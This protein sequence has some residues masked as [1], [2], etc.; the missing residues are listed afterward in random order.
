VT[1][2]AGLQRALRLAKK[3]RSLALDVV[4]KGKERKVKLEW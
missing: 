2:P 3:S 4:R 1:S